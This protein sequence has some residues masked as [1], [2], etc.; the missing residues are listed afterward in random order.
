MPLHSYLSPPKLQNG[1]RPNHIQEPPLHPK[2][3][4]NKQR[5]SAAV[6]SKRE[7]NVIAVHQI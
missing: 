4:S 5:K 2:P 1:P 6:Q 7:E 3:G